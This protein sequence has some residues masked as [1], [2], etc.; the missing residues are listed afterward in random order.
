M[1]E[2]KQRE[3]FTFYRSFRDTIEQIGVEADQLRIY[4]ALADYALDGK[5]PNLETLT[6][7]GLLCWTALRPIIH[8]G[9]KNYLNGIKGGAPKGN[10]NAR[11]NNPKTTQKQPKNKQ[12]IK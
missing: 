7:L 8:S 2:S 10:T 3:G 12:C 5:E 6:Q 11:K 4:K 9:R 1:A